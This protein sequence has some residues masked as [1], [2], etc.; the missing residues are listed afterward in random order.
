MSA[1]LLGMLVAS[2]K[3]PYVSG[4]VP[5]NITVQIRGVAIKAAAYSGDPCKPERRPVHQVLQIQLHG[6]INFT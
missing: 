6:S 3:N 5:V 2:A 4:I 1:L